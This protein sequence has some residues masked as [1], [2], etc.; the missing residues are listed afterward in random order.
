MS[1]ALLGAAFGA[2]IG[3]IISDFLGRKPA[4]IFSDMILILGPAILW[5]ATTVEYLLVGRIIVG[6]GIGI[7]MM[8]SNIYLAE[9]SPNKVRG[10]IA[11]SYQVFVS[12]GVILS[13]ITGAT[14]TNWNLMLGLALFP[15]II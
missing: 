1:L 4:L 6:F 10:A 2:L 13:F 9:Y 14:L 11:T 3:G 7:S 8:V 15:A 12:I 5:G